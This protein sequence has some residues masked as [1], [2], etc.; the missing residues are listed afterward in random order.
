[1]PDRDFPKVPDHR[2]AR[3]RKMEHRARRPS[4][5]DFGQRGKFARMR[6]WRATDDLGHKAVTDVVNHFDYHATLLHLFGMDARKLTFKRP[7]GEGSLLDGQAGRIVWEIL[8]R[9]K[10]E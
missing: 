7:N 9:G 4:D 5:R 8:K 3:V 1:M 6:S 2:E 10:S